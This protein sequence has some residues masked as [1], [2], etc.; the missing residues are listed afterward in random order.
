MNGRRSLERI[1]LV[2]T[3]NTGKSTLFNALTGGFAET[4]NFTGTTV[5]VEQGHL[6][7]ESRR[8]GILDLPG[9]VSLA[10]QAPD[11]AVAVRALLSAGTGDVVLFVADAPRLSRSLY[12]LLQVLELGLP[13]V[14][15]LN[16]VDEAEA[17]GIQ[18]DPEALSNLLGVSVTRINARRRTGLEGLVAAMIEAAE[19]T[20]PP[21]PS[22]VWPDRVVHAVDRIVAAWSP[23]G[24]PEGGASAD[25]VARWALLSEDEAVAA[26]GLPLAPVQQAREALE[27][28][29]VDVDQALVA[30]RYSWI[31]AH[32]PAVLGGGVQ[33]MRE[34]EWSRRLD[35]VLLHPL[36]GGL[37]FL[38]T[39]WVMFSALFSWSDPM[40]GAIEHV[41]SALGGL[42]G[43]GLDALAVSL[44]SMAWGLELLRGLVVDGVI[45]GVGGVLVFIPQVALLFLFLALLEDSGYLA[46]AA[47]IMDR[48][49]RF[50]GLPGKAFVPLLSG[51]AC[52]VP[53]ILATRTMPRFRDRLLTMMVIP[54]TSC[55]ARLPV[56]V[57]L[58][59]ALFPAVVPGTSISLRPLVLMGMYAFSTAL[60]LLAAVVLSALMMPAS[61]DAAVL[62]LPP[63]RVPSGRSV[64][65]SV[66][67]RTSEFVREAGR[68]ILMSTVVLWAL[69]AFPRY[70]PEEIV[71]PEVM[72]Q[73]VAE[74]ADIEELGATY[75]LRHSYGGRLGRLIEPVIAPLGY[76]WKIGVGLIGSFAAREVFV[77]T[78]GIVHGITDA[79]E[80]TS[81]LREAI[82]N[83]RH[84]DG[85]KVF[86][87]LVGVSLM[88]FF[89]IAMQCLSTLAVLRKE[90]GG[91]QW[92]M[93][94]TAYLTA[95]AWLAAFAVYQGG[96]LLGFG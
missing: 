21:A 35:S 61:A 72:A 6:K 92:P 59:G 22:P 49:L 36:S 32:L 51:Y 20:P 42:V 27:A 30:A 53:A 44:P 85:T 38:T 75:A 57:L 83:D 7:L 15:A 17:A 33:Y 65:R 43:G 19:A 84:A 74:G 39:M 9:T 77:S 82:R 76:D 18:V 8:V 48:V 88:A 78:M 87:P 40:I 5:H 23:E 58:I 89:A 93:F 73:A 37:A 79:D 28:E 10:A 4:G 52:A 71:P 55:S 3:P 90:T 16:L 91:W 14:V 64:L 29:D 12:L 95:A 41:F 62:E 86:T 70:T 34:P 13:V 94:A 80:E 63:Y 69:L 60:A 56:Y 25:A 2:G 46:R 67:T 1:L 81:G 24:L 66:W 50:A 31:D 96:L 47:H 11:E 54:L 26:A 45:A 68:V